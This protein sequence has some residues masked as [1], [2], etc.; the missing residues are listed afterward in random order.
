M[1]IEISRKRI[2]DIKADGEI[3]FVLKNKLD[4]KWVTDKNDLA[5]LQ[6]KAEADQ[7][8]LFAHSRKVYVGLESFRPDDLRSACAQALKFF[9]SANCSSL[10]IGMYVEENAQA[11]AQAMAEGF[12]LGDY[13]FLKYKSKPKKTN[14]PNKIIFA[15]EEYAD[16][17]VDEKKA[18]A[19]VRQ[20]GIIASA[21]NYTRE[22]INHTPDDVT[23]EKFAGLAKKLAKDIRIGISV[24][25]EKYLLKHNMNAF[26]A[27]SRG[28][29]HE[30]R[31]IHLAYKPK[32]A[33]TRVVL[34]GKGITYDSG[35]LS[36]KPSDSMITMKS[37]K[38]GAAA[39]LG[40]LQAAAGLKLPVEIHGIVGATENMIGHNAYKPDDVLR[41]KNGKTIEVRNTDA[42]GRLVLADCLA[43]AQDFQ[44]DYL[45]DLATLT[46]ACMV[47]LGEYTIGV[48]GYNSELKNKILAASAESGELAAELPFNKYLA[49]L[50]KS[51]V[52]DI[53]NVT[54]SKYGGAITAGLFL[55]EFIDR[56]NR[57]K[58]VH[59]DIAGPSYQEKEWDCNPYGASGAGVRL[60]VKFL[61]SIK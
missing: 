50:I 36:L 54:G 60:V 6:F 59:L 45:L 3:V 58:W 33:R 12:H 51:Q 15:L 23:P 53:K 34:V 14:Q 20:G 13:E 17:K 43:F 29:I 55:G 56:K 35:G 11:S 21:V 46:G 61:Q 47:A 8:L 31:L 48:M 5:F 32:N 44:P 30:P 57:D 19:G 26:Y 24:Y 28:S 39:V 1:K 41:A 4:H 2:K 27:V 37:D 16:K 42:E 52:A 9:R 38:S 18:S 40:I 22:I 49:K 7:A 25:D 10:K